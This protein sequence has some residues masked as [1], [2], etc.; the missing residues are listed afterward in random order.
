MTYG[1]SIIVH[2]VYRPSSAP[3]AHVK[4]TMVAFFWLEKQVRVTGEKKQAT[5]S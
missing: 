2:F 1:P 3:T 4:L 5:A